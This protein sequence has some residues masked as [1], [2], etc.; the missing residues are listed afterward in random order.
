[1]G[2]TEYLSLNANDIQVPDVS[3]YVTS[4]YAG[5]AIVTATTKSVEID[6]ILFCFYRLLEHTNVLARVNI[7]SYKNVQIENNSYARFDLIQLVIIHSA[8]G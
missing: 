6:L 4:E 2:N 3:F 7:N 1:M 8:S 5:W